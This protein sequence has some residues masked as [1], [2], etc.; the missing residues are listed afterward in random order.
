[1]KKRAF[2]P[3]GE[4][5]RPDTKVFCIGFQKTGTSSL[6]DALRQLGYS[7]T[8]VYG[9]DLSLE[10]LRETYLENGLKLAEQFDAVEDAPWPSI[11]KELDAAFPGSKFILSVRDTETWWGSILGHFGDNSAPMHQLTYGEDAPHPAGNEELYKRVYEAHNASVREHFADRPDQLLELWLERGQGWKE[12][13]EFLGIEGV[14]EG[15][16]VHTNSSKQRNS[17]YHR[18]RR[19]LA[20]YGVPYQPLGY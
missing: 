6:R 1:M 12:L 18:I 10:E 5:Q 13:G 15:P 11:F 4:M 14:R 20:R 17:L 9:D 8:G 7:V 19:R 2:K 16:F 3:T